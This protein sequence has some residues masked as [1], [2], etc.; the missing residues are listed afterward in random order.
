MFNDPKSI[1]F[2]AIPVLKLHPLE[3]AAVNLSY[4]LYAANFLP[5]IPLL[6]FM[7]FLFL[8]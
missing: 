5:A 7:T 8:A 3:A 2:N 4:P 1:F 6:I